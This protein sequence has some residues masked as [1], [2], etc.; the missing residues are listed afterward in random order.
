MHFEH[1][2]M[3]TCREAQRLMA[4]YVNNDPTLSREEREGF[5]QHLRICPSCAAEFEE[6]KHLTALL[7][8][9]WPISEDTRKLLQSVGHDVEAQEE[10]CTCD[11]PYRPMTVEEGWEDLKRRCPSLAEA[12]RRDERK[13]K[14]R[15]MVWR[16][17][18]LA[19]AACILIAVGVGFLMLRSGSDQ[20]GSDV[21]ANQDKLRAVYAELVTAKGRKSLALDRLPYT[22]W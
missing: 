16:I 21:A 22:R 20:P 5:E 9:Y 11:Q 14:L 17:G 18:N 12:C 1:E 15:R 7:R 10:L 13:R 6:D 8:R 3:L 4:F 2:N 19:V